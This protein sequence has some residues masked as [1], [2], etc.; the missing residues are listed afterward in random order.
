MVQ[1][2]QVRRLED[3]GAVRRS[4][5]PDDGRVA[6][7]ELTAKGR[8]MAENLRTVGIGHLADALHEW[9]EA[10]SRNLAS[11]LGRFVDDVMATPVPRLENASRDTSA[12][13]RTT[14]SAVE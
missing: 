1:R 4:G 9:T 14:A 10:D 3:V 7:L 8:R 5:D 6:F 12:K 13:R 11:L 2:W